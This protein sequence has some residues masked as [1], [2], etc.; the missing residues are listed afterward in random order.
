MRNK[1][2]AVSIQTRDGIKFSSKAEHE[3]YQQLVWLHQAGEIKFFLR[4]TP[5]HL[6]GGVKYLVDFSIFENDGSVRFVDVKG[7]ETKE[8]KIK[9][10]LVEAIYPVKIEIIKSRGRNANFKENKKTV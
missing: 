1:Y 8:F 10:K 4:Q 9:K 3:F 7:F 6:P 2:C 5:F